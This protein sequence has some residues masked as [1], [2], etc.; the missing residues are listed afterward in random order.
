MGATCAVYSRYIHPSKIVSEKYPNRAHAH[1]LHDLVAIRKEKKVVNRVERDV[2]IFR[3]DNF[4]AV[5]LHTVLRW[6]KVVTEGPPDQFFVDRPPPVA[7]EENDGSVNVGEPIPDHVF[8]MHGQAEDIAHV[9]GLG[10]EVDDDNDPAPENMPGQTDGVEG[11]FEAPSAEKWE[12]ICPRK[13]IN[14]RNNEPALKGVT[15]ETVGGLSYLDMFLIALPVT[16]L[17]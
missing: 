17:K 7:E 15:D 9:R 3:H 5:E 16:Y 4:P 8:H 13:M 2:I 12:G 14:V 6:A 10:F 1:I 11:T